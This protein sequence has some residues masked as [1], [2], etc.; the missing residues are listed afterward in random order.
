MSQKVGH[1]ATHQPALLSN[2][3][4]PGSEYTA[5]FSRSRRNFYVSFFA[6]TKDAGADTRGCGVCADLPPIRK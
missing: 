2:L 5:F 6:P 4:P 1:V 3:S